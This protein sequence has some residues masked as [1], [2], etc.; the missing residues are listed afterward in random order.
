MQK[1]DL[2]CCIAVLETMSHTHR[3]QLHTE[4]AV[5]SIHLHP[6]WL[7]P[8]ALGLGPSDQN[9]ALNSPT[10]LFGGLDTQKQIYEIYI[11]IFNA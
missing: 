2:T 3:T 6:L 10:A 9:K 11:C 7:H 5:N 1:N 8:K 4:E